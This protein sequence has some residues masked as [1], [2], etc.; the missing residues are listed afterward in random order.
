VFLSSRGKKECASFI[1]I[2]KKLMGRQ[3]RA[4]KKRGKLRRCRSWQKGKGKKTQTEVFLGRKG[5]KVNRDST[6]SREKREV[7]FLSGG[8]SASIFWEG[9][10]SRTSERK[11][12]VGG[13]AGRKGPPYCLSEEKGQIIRLRTGKVA[14]VVPKTGARGRRAWRKKRRGIQ[15]LQSEKFTPG[16]DLWRKKKDNRNPAA[17][18]KRGSRMLVFAERGKRV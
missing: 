3:K 2:R 11:R 4:G 13:V 17:E 7:A 12:T 18:K 8:A 16:G 5:E 9:A 1:D 6:A 10:S 14:E 15:R